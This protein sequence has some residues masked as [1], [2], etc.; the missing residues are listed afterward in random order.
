M[1]WVLDDLE[2]ECVSWTV[3]PGGSSPVCGARRIASHRATCSPLPLISNRGPFGARRYPLLLLV[4][5]ALLGQSCSS[6]PA[7]AL[8]SAHASHALTDEEVVASAKRALRV[9]W[10]HEP[11]LSRYRIS[12]HRSED[13][14]ASAQ[15]ENCYYSFVAGP[16]GT[17]A[18]VA[19]EVISITLDRFGHVK[20]IPVCCDLGDCPEFCL[21]PDKLPALTTVT[22]T[23]LDPEGRGLAGALVQVFAGGYVEVRSATSGPDGGFSIRSFPACNWVL[24]AK[25]NGE[26]HGELLMVAKFGGVTPVPGA[27][28]DLGAFELAVEPPSRPD[29]FSTITGR[30]VDGAGRS[31]VEAQIAVDA[32]DHILLGTPDFNGRFSISGVP[33]RHGSITVSA[34]SRSGCVVYAPS[35]PLPRIVVKPGDTVDVGTIV[36]RP[37]KW[38]AQD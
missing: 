28:T 22:G 3:T 5:G 14:R 16:V 1:Q 38:P 10:G 4:L 23:V 2:I 33:T 36:L 13:C 17:E 11:D 32:G 9:M 29:D 20:T 21:P 24:Y 8:S 35:R 34:S 19:R 6:L 12:V 26:M 25:A 7:A 27:V 37:A 31:A 15:S 30:V 18:L